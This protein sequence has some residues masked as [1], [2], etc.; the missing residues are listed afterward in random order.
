V[1]IKSTSL[2]SEL[3]FREGEGVS[4]M[5]NAVHIRIR[6]SAEEFFCLLVRCVHF[7]GFGIRPLLLNTLFDLNEMVCIYGNTSM[8]VVSVAKIPAACVQGYEKQCFVIKTI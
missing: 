4:Q 2:T 3:N 7:K 6:E 8:R 1:A 5:Q